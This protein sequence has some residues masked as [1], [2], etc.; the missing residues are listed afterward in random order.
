[1]DRARGRKFLNYNLLTAGGPSD[2]RLFGLP[3]RHHAAPEEVG[4]L[5]RP[6]P[7]QPREAPPQQGLSPQG[8]MAQMPEP[9]ISQPSQ[10]FA[11]TVLPAALA[12]PGRAAAEAGLGFPVGGPPPA[13]PAPTG[14][15]L[16]PSGLDGLGAA[17][18]AA[19][20]E[21]RR[22]QEEMRRA[23]E[24]QMAQKDRATPH[25]LGGSPLHQLGGAQNPPSAPGPCTPSGLGGLGAASE[26]AQLDR[27][28]RQEE[29]RRAL[30]EQ[31]AEKERLAQAGALRPQLG[32][33]V[34][35]Y[36][37]H[38]VAAQPTHPSMQPGMQP[39]MQ[40][41]IQPGMQAGM[42]PGMPAMMAGAA[43]QPP[44]PVAQGANPAA[45]QLPRAGV[46]GL[47]AAGDAVQ[48]E[49]RRKLPG[50]ASGIPLLFQ[51]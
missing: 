50:R 30:E 31:M 42:Q 18:D 9:Q 34:Y 16:A 14:M 22:R 13:A 43:P 38:P 32:S 5:G 29:M 26:A 8:G 51:E 47:G 7:A 1:M 15:A 4:Q 10:P 2:A 25:G 23:L 21:R 33:D 20:S 41:G 19:Q 39:G 49:R 40:Q 11:A 27:R 17:G 28:R 35:A 37:G 6:M 24:E 48:M 36:N 12:S 45:G 3:S 44:A 46:D